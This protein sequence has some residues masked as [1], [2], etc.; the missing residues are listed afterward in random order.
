MKKSKLFGTK[1]LFCKHVYAR[2]G[3]ASWKYLRPVLIDF[4]DWFRTEIGQSVYVNDWGVGKSKTQRGFRCNLCP[5]VA[6]KKTLYV[7]AH[8][9][10]C[11][12]DFNVAVFTPDE[13]REWLEG[14]IKEFFDKF[15][16]YTAKCRLE[17]SEIATTWVH[18]DFY[19]HDEPAIIKYVKPIK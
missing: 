9:T 16:Q 11:G 17:S 13:I 7:S 19:E 12:V 10:G 3:D 8:M 5:E 6:N 14:H 4:L 15:P 18:I 2:D 1:E